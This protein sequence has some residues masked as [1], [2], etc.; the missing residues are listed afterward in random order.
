M[1]RKRRVIKVEIDRL[2]SVIDK[3][4]QNTPNDHEFKYNVFES[5]GKTTIAYTY[6]KIPFDWRG[7]DR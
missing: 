6:T 1:H 3:L 2:S 4:I 7:Y 5:Y